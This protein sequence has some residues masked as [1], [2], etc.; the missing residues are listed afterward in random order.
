[1]TIQNIQ[2]KCNVRDV[3]ERPRK[4]KKGEMTMRKPNNAP[5]YPNLVAEM[6]RTGIEIQDLG[7]ATGKSK[8]SMYDYLRGV[9]NGGF[10]IDEAFA[11][12]EAY[13]PG[14]TIAYLFARSPEP[15]AAVATA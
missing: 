1:M 8:S 14:M 6:S 9:G 15:G 12:Q 7:Q 11:I 2:D 3:V 4:L 10:T 13:F 5:K